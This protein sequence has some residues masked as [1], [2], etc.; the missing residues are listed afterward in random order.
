VQGTWGTPSPG[1]AYTVGTTIGARGLCTPHLFQV[2]LLYGPPTFLC[3]DPPQLQIRGA[4]LAS[5]ACKGG[6][7]YLKLGGSIFQ[8]SLLPMTWHSLTQH[9]FVLALLIGIG[10]TAGIL[11]LICA[12][13]VQRHWMAL[14]LN[15]RSSNRHVKLINEEGVDW[16]PQV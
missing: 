7:T 9:V 6:A 14:R 4:A 8:V 15:R 2:Y 16:M 3:I 13:L 5:A 1:Q 12:V 10:L 11:V